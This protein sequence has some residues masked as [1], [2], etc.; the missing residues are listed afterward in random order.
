MGPNLSGVVGRPA[1]ALPDYAYSPAVRAAG[2]IWT[3][4]RMDQFVQ[5]PR[6]AIPGN[7]MPFAGIASADE[8]RAIITYLQT[9]KP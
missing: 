7:R 1:A 3:V 9:L 5:N 8:R 6:A 4:R 2:G